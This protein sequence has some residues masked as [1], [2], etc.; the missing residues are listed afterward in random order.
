MGIIVT[1]D[2]VDGTGKSTIARLLAVDGNY[3]YFKTPSGPFA[4]LRSEVDKH[5]TPLERYCFY[6]LATQHDSVRLRQL[7]KDGAVVCDRYIASTL[8]YHLT[9]DS[10]IAD[11]HNNGEVLIPDFSFLL[12]TE[13]R[14]RNRRLDIRAT[15]A[16]D[17]ALEQNRELLDRVEETFRGLN[18]LG[19]LPFKLITVDTTHRTPREVASTIE[20]HIRGGNDAKATSL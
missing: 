11:I 18:D 14:E 20:A 15:M 9:M 16:S 10:R 1:L 4:Q 17:A 6:R 5:A 13:S 3:R 19:C 7:S 8:A 2:G 12:T